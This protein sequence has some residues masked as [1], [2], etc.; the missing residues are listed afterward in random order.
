MATLRPELPLAGRRILVCRPK[1][2]SHRLSEY[3]R[4][5][6]AVVKEF[7]LLERQRLEETPAQRTLIQNLDQFAHVIAVSPFA[8]QLLLER[9]DIWWPQPPVG[10]KWYGVGAATAETLTSG[11]IKSQAPATG[12]TSEHLL[13]L[14]DLATLAGERILLARGEQGRELL[15]DTL[16]QRGADV[17][18]LALYRRDCPTYSNAQRE[19]AL[20]TFSPEVI[21]TLSGETLN[22]LVALSQN[23][24]HNLK[25]QLLV[26]PAERVA[27]QA[28]NAGFKWISLPAALDDNAILTCITEQLA[29]RDQ[30]I[31]E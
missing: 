15:R 13:E 14:P 27:Q 23:T 4:Q 25:Q 24:N 21:I 3:L 9:L 31:P 29:E 2:E 18:E 22:N 5:A 6:G 17:T 1:P 16:T 10:I 30:H 12:F 8:A 26:V 28:R 19:D 11:G 7:P 20:G